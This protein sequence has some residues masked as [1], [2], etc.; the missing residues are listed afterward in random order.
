VFLL[1]DGKARKQFPLALKVGFK[2][3]EE[4]ALAKTPGPPQE[5]GGQGGYQPVDIPRLIDVDTSGSAEFFKTLYPY[6]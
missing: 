1:F 5:N 2:G 6:G 4:Q 3:G